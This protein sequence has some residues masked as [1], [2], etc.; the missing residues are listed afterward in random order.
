MLVL[1]R[2]EQGEKNFFDIYILPTAML[3]ALAIR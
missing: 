2:G 3:L 1:S